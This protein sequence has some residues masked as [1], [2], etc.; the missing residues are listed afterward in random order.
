MLKKGVLL[1]VLS[2]PFQWNAVAQTVNNDMTEAIELQIDQPFTSKTDGNTVQY[3]CIDQQLTG[4]CIQ[5]HN[6]QWFTFTNTNYD[7][8][9]INIGNQQCRDLRGVQLVA[10]EGELC[11]PDTYKILDCISLATQDDIY[12]TISPLKHDQKY[13]LNIDGYLHDY[14][15]FELEVSLRPKGVSA[16]PIGLIKKVSQQKK[17]SVIQLN[18]S[19]NDSLAQ[20]LQN[21]I[22]MRREDSAFSFDSLA[23][24]PVEFNTFGAYQPDYIFTDQLYEPGVYWYRIIA[25]NTEGHKL[26]TEELSFQINSIDLSKTVLFLDYEENDDIVISV[27]SDNNKLLDTIKLRYKSREHRN[28]PLYLDKYKKRLLKH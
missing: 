4:K 9:Y 2:G 24:V 11:A 16:K 15:Q 3:A 27:Y 21:F 12:A 22:I 7:T 19:I 20:S 17:K 25:Q 10:F 18:W 26:I 6:D 8:L 23:S 1:I 13:W 5:Y 28:F 14:C